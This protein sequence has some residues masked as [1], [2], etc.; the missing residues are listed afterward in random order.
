MKLPDHTLRSKIQT[1]L[2][3]PI[4]VFLKG[5][6]SNNLSKDNY[7]MVPWP[8]EKLRSYEQLYLDE[9]TLI[10]RN[11]EKSPYRDD[12]AEWNDEILAFDSEGE[13][14]SATAN[15]SSDGR[16]LGSITFGLGGD[17]DASTPSE[18]ATQIEIYVKG[19][20]E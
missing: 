8:P 18:M 11:D 15:F 7:I 12:S 17:I 4:L 10:F 3:V 2:I 19:F 9:N 20:G 1:I 14:I 5:S 6:P 16:I 13:V